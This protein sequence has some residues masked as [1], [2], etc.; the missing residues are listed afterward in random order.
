M[1]ERTVLH[2]FYPSLFFCTCYLMEYIISDGIFGFV[3][4]FEFFCLVHIGFDTFCV[5]VYIYCFL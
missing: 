3:C 4:L 1:I 2:F 5:C